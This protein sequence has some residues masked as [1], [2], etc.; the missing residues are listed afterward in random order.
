MRTWSVGCGERRHMRLPVASG[1]IGPR[2]VRAGN[3]TWR[4]RTVVSVAL[5]GGIV[6]TGCSSS[7]T[8]SGPGHIK[9]VPTTKSPRPKAETIDGVPLIPITSVQRAHCVQFAHQRKRSIPCPGLLPDPIPVSASAAGSCLGG[10]GEDGCGPARI[11]VTNSVL[12]FN[13]SNFQVPPD[14]AGVT[15][16][17]YNGAVVPETSISGGPLGHFV[18]TAAVGEQVSNVPSYCAPQAVGDVIHVHGAVASLYQCGSPGSS[19][20]T[21]QLIQGH[22]LLAWNDAGILCEVSF[23][24]FSQANVDLDVAVAD[25]I[26]TIS[27]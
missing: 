1:V 3:V 19:P 14:Y 13:Q 26:E 16:Q 25:A 23:H 11:Q 15:L 17:Q 7:P 22:Q 2:Q 21:L 9:S 12:L 6:L 4:Y 24:G 20:G 8:L 5:F 18:F 10:L 27:P